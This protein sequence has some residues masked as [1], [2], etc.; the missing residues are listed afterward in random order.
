VQ[1]FLFSAQ[2]HLPSFHLNVCFSKPGPPRS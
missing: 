1:F 2:H